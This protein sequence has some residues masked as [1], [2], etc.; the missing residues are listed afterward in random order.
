MLGYHVLLSDQI[1]L[2]PIIHSQTRVV[3]QTWPARPFSRWKECSAFFICALNAS[4]CRTYHAMLYSIIHSILH[5]STSS[6][7]S[8]RVYCLQAHS[9]G[10]ETA[11][12]WSAHVLLLHDN[13]SPVPR[14]S[15]T[16]SHFSPSSR[17]RAQIGTT[18]PS[19]PEVPEHTPS[20]TT[21]NTSI[22]DLCRAGIA[23]HLAELKLGLRARALG[24]RGV[25]DDVAESLSVQVVLISLKSY[26]PIGI[27]KSY[28]SGS[29]CSK[30]LRLVWS[31][32][33]MMLTKQPRSSFFA[34]NCAIAPAI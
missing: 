1:S 5:S 11:T 27:A 32:M 28:L 15:D 17:R 4:L 33:F 25:A 24:E 6:P 2:S 31:R 22:P 23:V 29:C 20:L 12:D 34:R 18:H 30:T 21:H 9:C 14:H 13:E 7:S 19:H 16:S 26:G 3:L 8:P 10:I